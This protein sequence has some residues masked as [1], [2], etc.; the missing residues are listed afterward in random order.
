[1]CAGA[2]R[3]ARRT[4]SLRVAISCDA[5]GT[6]ARRLAEPLAPGADLAKTH[7][8]LSFL[9]DVFVVVD[10][11]QLELH[12]ELHECLLDRSVVGQLL[13]DD[14]P[15]LAK[16][17]LDPGD[18]TSDWEEEEVGYQAHWKGGTGGTVERWN[19]TT[20]VILRS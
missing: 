5:N 3:G 7:H 15:H 17:P 1:M 14:L 11:A 8:E 6:A 9:A 20:S 16:G 2:G 13:P 12:L 19:E 10:V 18:R 4:R